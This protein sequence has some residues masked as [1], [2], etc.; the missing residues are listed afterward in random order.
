MP[1]QQDKATADTACISTAPFWVGDGLPKRP[2]SGWWAFYVH[3][4]KGVHP[5][6]VKGQTAIWLLWLAALAA[7]AFLPQFI[8]FCGAMMAVVLVSSV[9]VCQ[10]VCA[11]IRG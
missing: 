6:S 11:F 2:D 7:T 5:G 8:H 9:V 3:N 10:C 1:L 4:S